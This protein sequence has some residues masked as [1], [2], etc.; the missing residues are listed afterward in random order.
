MAA[1]DDQ[2]RQEARL[3]DGERR[4]LALVQRNMTSKEIALELELS[5]YTVDGYIKSAMA[6]LRAPNRREAARLAAS[7]AIPQQLGGQPAAIVKSDPDGEKSIS[8]ETPSGAQKRLWIPPLGGPRHHLSQ[9]D[10][11]FVIFKISAVAIAV[12]AGTTL[13]VAVLLWMIPGSS[14]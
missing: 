14:P 7:A 8:A 3:S 13:A 4:C 5:P 11:L 6:K 2:G 9:A 10:K 1:E 12:L